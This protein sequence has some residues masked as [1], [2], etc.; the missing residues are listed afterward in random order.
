M[1][2]TFLACVMNFISFEKA[3]SLYVQYEAAWEEKD[4]S[5]DTGMNLQQVKVVDPVFKL[6]L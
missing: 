5:K 6:T 4:V 3:Y 1:P 2:I